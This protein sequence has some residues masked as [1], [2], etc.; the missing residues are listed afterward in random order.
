M[1]TGRWCEVHSRAVEAAAVRWGFPVD[2]PLSLLSQRTGYRYS[3][4]LVVAAGEGGS[5]INADDRLWLG[6]DRG[7]GSEGV[8]V[9]VG[10]VAFVSGVVCD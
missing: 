5:S 8:E 7:E 10:V 9:T 2:C 1:E 3:L 4:S 6:G